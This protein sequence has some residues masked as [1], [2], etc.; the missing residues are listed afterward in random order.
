M[1]IGGSVWATFINWKLALVVSTILP[2][3]AILGSLHVL[4]RHIAVFSMVM[5]V[6]YQH[7]YI[8]FQA[9]KTLTAKENAAYFKIGSKSPS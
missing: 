8:D 9:F 5:Y 3:I 2:M 4:V 1:F 7:H 6:L